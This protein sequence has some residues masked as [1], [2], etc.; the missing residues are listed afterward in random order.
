VSIYIIPTLALPLAGLIK[1]LHKSTVFPCLLTES[2]ILAHVVNVILL[3]LFS[4]I[5]PDVP[6]ILI[7][8]IVL[9]SIYCL[10]V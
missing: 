4:S 1:A 5:Y 8:F 7:F 9:L 10:V 2:G 6:L 3:I